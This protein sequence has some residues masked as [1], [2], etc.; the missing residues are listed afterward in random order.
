M[1]FLGGL[2]GLVWLFVVDPSDVG[3]VPGCPFHA[4]TG[5]YCPGCGTLRCLHTL[6][7]G[8]VATAVGYNALTV[9][10]LPFLLI[11]WLSAGTVALDRRGEVDVKLQ[12]RTIRGI[13]IAAFVFWVIRNLPWAPFSWL[14]P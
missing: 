9:L 5:L 11:A 1:L 14:A 4:A 6:L 13:A 3:G 7:H 8:D 2:A 12:G 10:L